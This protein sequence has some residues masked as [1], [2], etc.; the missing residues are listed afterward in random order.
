MTTL[1]FCGCKKDAVC[2]YSN[3]V[4]SNADHLICQVNYHR[5]KDFNPNDKDHY[6][7]VWGAKDCPVPPEPLQPILEQRGKEYGDF[8]SMCARIQAIKDAMCLNRRDTEDAR[9]PLHSIHVEA[10]EMIA[11]KI[12]RIL[13]GNPNNEDSWRDIAGYATLVA[14]RIPK[15]KE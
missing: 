7:N 3:R 11:T 6:R 9:N 2:A 1:Q 15:K 13:T 14:D 4:S 8:Y 5:G 12:G 10:L